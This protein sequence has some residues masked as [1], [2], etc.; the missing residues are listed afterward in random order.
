MPTAS[1]KPVPRRGRPARPLP[2]PVIVPTLAAP[3]STDMGAPLSKPADPLAGYEEMMRLGTEAV[4]ALLSTTNLMA[5]GMRTLS[6][7]IAAFTQGA[8]E[9]SVS[10]SKAMY[11]T[12][13]L[14]ELF[15]LTQSTAKAQIGA[16]ADEGAKLAHLS[17]ELAQ[18][19]AA[20][21]KDRMDAAVA[22]LSRLA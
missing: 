15:D 11:E 20:P 21:F 8:L 7:E 6:N 4:N 1:D 3:A 14:Y 9:R 19:A 17:T 18:Q 2:A 22:S 10:A 5:S 12:R 13:S 16:L